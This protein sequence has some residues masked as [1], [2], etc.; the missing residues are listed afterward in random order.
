MKFESHRL[1]LFENAALVKHQ[2]FQMK[3]PGKIKGTL[4][5]Q[6]TSYSVEER[7]PFSMVILPRVVITSNL[8]LLLF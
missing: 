1:R 5:D 6:S 8:T 3:C 4:E 2:A 7:R